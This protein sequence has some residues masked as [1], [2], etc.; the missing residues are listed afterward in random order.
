MQTLAPGAIFKFGQTWGKLL[1]RKAFT[2]GSEIGLIFSGILIGIGAGC[3]VSGM[4]WISKALHSLIF[5]IEMSEWLSASEIENKLIV[6]CAPIVGGIVLGCVLFILSRRRKRAMVDPIEA[7]AL[8]GGRISLTDSV[9]VAVQN[10]ISNGFGASVGLEAGYTQLSAGLASKL[11]SKLKLRREDMRVLVGCGAAGAIAA[12]FN[13]PLTGA[14]YA[15]E[16]I[17]GTYSMV[18]LAPVVVSAIVATFVARGFSGDSFLIEVGEIGTITPADYI[19]AIALGAICAGVGILIMQGVAFIE[20][21]ARKSSLPPYLRPALGG[22]LIGLMAM[23]T[24]QVLS[25]GHGALH[26]N[27][28]SQAPV[29]VL[30]GLFLLKSVA[31]AVSI[32]SGFR[33]GLFFASLFMGALLGKIFAMPADFITTGSLTPTVLA[34]VGMSALAVA[35]IGGPLTMTFLAL[36]ITADFPITALV[37]AAVITSS[38]VVRNTFGY[39]FATWRFHLRGES[40][41]SAHDV[42]WIRN[43]TVDKLMRSDVKCAK[44]GVSL[45]EFREAF[46]L[47]SAKRAI[48]LD[49]ND[50]YA[51]IVSIPEVYA[52]EVESTKP[53]TEVKDFLQFE[54]DFLLPNMNAKQAAEIF[55]QAHAEALPVINN[56]I[57]RRVIGQLSEAHTLRRYSEELDRRRREA[58]GEA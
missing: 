35:I 40:I 54:N 50:R 15:F 8:Y 16:L 36:E 45:A 56:L 14:F 7:N 17:I 49:D 48:L 38:L 31:S 46:P 39:S 26:I 3:A 20:E 43:L 18:A 30:I 22:I 52:E 29:Q 57:D 6:L 4:S 2:R 47:G 28:D 12:A 25:A 55:D 23:I 58:V 42:G 32:G 44:L 24:P 41:R 21:T 19:P 1:K 53:R 37:L 51:G 34:V 10:L 11:G 5:G 9:I 33:G 13:A 27:L